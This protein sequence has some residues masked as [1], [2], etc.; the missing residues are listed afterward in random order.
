ME[1]KVEDDQDSSLPPTAAKTNWKKTCIALAI[2]LIGFASLIAFFDTKGSAQDS[3]EYATEE[4][5]EDDSA[6][7]LFEAARATGQ[8]Y[9]VGVG[10]ADITGFVV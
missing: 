7:Y 1:E 6:S 10:K 3:P 5:A 4:I 2:C 8:Q 9:L